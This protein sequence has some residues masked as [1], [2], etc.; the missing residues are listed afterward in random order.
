MIS[1]T[2][3]TW[4][5]LAARNRSTDIGL[6]R[7][8]RGRLRLLT[9]PVKFASGPLPGVRVPLLVKVIFSG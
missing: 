8:S 5:L 6:R 1:V 3:F 2:A 9:L 7:K 4:K